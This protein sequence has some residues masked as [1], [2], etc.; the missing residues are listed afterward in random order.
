MTTLGYALAGA[1]TGWIIWRLAPRW[2]SGR[3]EK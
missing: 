3:K 1:L 2:L